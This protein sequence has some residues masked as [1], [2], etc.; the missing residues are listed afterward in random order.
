M[1]ARNA[2]TL[3]FYEGSYG[4][5]GLDAQRR[6]PNEEL[7]RFMG[8]HYF[9]MKLGNRRNVRILEAGCGSGSN[10]WMIAREGFDAHGFD[11]S[12]TSIEL[13]KQMLANHGVTA[14]L[15]VGDMA[16]MP[17]PAACFD[18]IVDVFSSYCLDDAGHASFLDGV[19]RLLKPGGRFFI[20][21]PGKG[22]TDWIGPGNVREAPGSPRV[23]PNNVYPFRYTSVDELAADLEARGLTVT[24]AETLR[25]T[26][27]K[28]TTVFEFVVIEAQAH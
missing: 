19:Q 27:E 20:L 6:Y 25:R 11:F 28:G 3:D 22:S 10:L 23:Y 15:K 2:Q 9:R 24:G 14:E 18:A 7:C 5:A 8:R 16:S 17:Y 13:C 4:S 1:P 12:P 21:T 26:Y